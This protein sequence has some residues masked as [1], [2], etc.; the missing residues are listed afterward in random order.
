MRAIT[1]L[2]RTARPISGGGARYQRVF[3]RIAAP[4]RAIDA[5]QRHRPVTSCAVPFSEVSTSWVRFA[6]RVRAN[7]SGFRLPS[8][9]KWMTDGWR[10]ELTASSGNQHPRTR[11][12]DARRQRA[13][14]HF[15]VGV[16]K[17]Q[18]ANMD[19]IMTGLVQESGERSR[20]RVVDQEP[21]SPAARG[22]ARSRTASAARSSVSRTSSA[23]RSGYSGDIPG[24]Q[25][26]H[27]LPTPY[28]FERLAARC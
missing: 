4:I 8:P 23:S 14:D 6:S 20:K 13:E 10:D 15:V 12:F 26:C 17:S 9:R 27:S 25:R 19:C 3:R 28:E 16:R 21:H 24:R 18:F 22:N 2:E 7:A 5:S 11:R 1:T